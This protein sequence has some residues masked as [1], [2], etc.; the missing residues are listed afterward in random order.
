LEIVERHAHSR[1]VPGSR[2]AHERD[3]TVFWNY[4]DLRFRSPRPFR[5]EA[6]LT[7]GM[8]EIVIRGVRKDTAGHLASLAI[9]R[10][11]A[12]DCT[13]CDETDCH[14]HG[15]EVKAPES[16]GRPAAWLVDACWP[17][18]ATWLAARAGKED[19][20]FLPQRLR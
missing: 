3:A 9:A 6:R 8:L 2:A 10:E 20:L 12:N 7:N 16:N 17:E 11:T 14:L 19:A 15:P 18:F 1:I 13:S 5:I 4:V